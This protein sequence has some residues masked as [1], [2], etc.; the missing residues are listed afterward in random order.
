[1][2]VGHFCHPAQICGQKAGDQVLEGDSE[3]SVGGGG[4][5]RGGLLPP[6]ARWLSPLSHTD[7]TPE[8]NGPVPQAA[9][10]GKYYLCRVC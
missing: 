1:M 7:Q 4:M 2:D 10:V 5:V 9:A 6:L 8:Q 3:D